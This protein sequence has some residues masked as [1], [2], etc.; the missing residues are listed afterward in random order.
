M[1]QAM[2]QYKNKIRNAYVLIYD[3]EEMY[4]MQKVNDI[5]DDLKSSQLSS[6]ELQKQYQ[7][8]KLV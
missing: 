1:I 5:V 8:C 3:R 2:T 6:K 4:D 7:A